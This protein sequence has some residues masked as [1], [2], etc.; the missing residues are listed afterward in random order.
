MDALLEQFAPD[1]LAIKNRKGY[2][3]VDRRSQ[4]QMIRQDEAVARAIML[5]P[6]ANLKKNTHG[7]WV[8]RTKEIAEIISLSLISINQFIFFVLLSHITL[9]DPSKL[10]K[11]EP[12]F[13]PNLS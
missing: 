11:F 2:K 8:L 10:Q 4:L 6:A 3:N 9:L 7:D 13:P 5:T 12:K 1:A